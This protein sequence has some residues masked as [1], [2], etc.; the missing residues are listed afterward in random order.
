MLAVSGSFFIQWMFSKVLLFK[1]IGRRESNE[2][3]NVSKNTFYGAGV[4]WLE[5]RLHHSLFCWK[6]DKIIG[7]IARTE[8]ILFFFFR[9]QN[10]ME[11]FQLNS[12]WNTSYDWPQ[13]CQ[14]CHRWIKLWSHIAHWND[15]SLYVW[16]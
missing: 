5:C 13:E 15:G 9:N 2:F 10:R 3:K 11:D 1:C 12:N 16:P 4:F 6:F 8:S 7:S 14:N